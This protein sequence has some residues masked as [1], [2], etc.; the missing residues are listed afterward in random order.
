LVTAVMGLVAAAVG[1]AA[2]VAQLAALSRLRRPQHSLG[3]PR[4]LRQLRNSRKI[5]DS[6]ESLCRNEDKT[7]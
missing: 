6:A 3:F 1:L 4:L 2:A 7:W 5:P